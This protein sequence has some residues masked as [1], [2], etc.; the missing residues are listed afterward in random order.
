MELSFFLK[1]KDDRRIKCLL[2]KMQEKRMRRK[3]DIFLNEPE[4]IVYQEN[5]DHLHVLQT[6]T[7]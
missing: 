1:K 3:V 5:I 4:G 2:C 6:L 7:V